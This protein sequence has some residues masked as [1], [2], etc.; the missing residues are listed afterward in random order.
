MGYVVKADFACSADLR[1]QE[2][3][4]ALRHWRIPISVGGR[5]MKS[6]IWAAVAAISLMCSL[7]AS[8][9]IVHYTITFNDPDGTGP[10]SGGSG[11]LTLNELVA[12]NLNENAPA[13]GES[14]VGTVNGVSFDINSSSFSQWSINLD[15]G[16]F[17]NL[18]LSSAVD[19]SVPGMLY[20]NLHGD[21]GYNVQ[22]TQG[23]DVINYGT[24]TIGPPGTE[25]TA[26][27]PEPSTWAMMILGFLGLGFVGYRRNRASGSAFRIA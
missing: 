10:K 25:V 20:L 19:Y 13:L 23:P 11:V 18:G 21:G 14:F 17:Y 26:A 9:A 8:A 7:P 2:Q 5:L 12:G 22:R 3:M 27:V 15:S 4:S 1:V 24:F 16:N 6:A